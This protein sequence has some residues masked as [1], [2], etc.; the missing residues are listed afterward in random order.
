MSTLPDA[1]AL[2]SGSEIP[3][4]L[5]IRI[6][7][8][9]PLADL[10][11][12]Q[13][14]SRDWKTLIQT[15]PALQYKIE[16]GLAGLADNPWNALDTATKRR[17]LATY[18]RAW[19]SNSKPI[20]PP[21]TL[22]VKRLGR[23]NIGGRPNFVLRPDFAGVF[24]VRDPDP[25]HGN[26]ESLSYEQFSSQYLDIE[27]KSIRVGPHPGDG[28]AFDMTQDLV[29]SAFQKTTDDFAIHLCCSML[30]T[31]MAHPL[32]GF[33]NTPPTPSTE[34]EGHFIINGPYVALL[35]Q[36]RTN[37]QTAKRSM[38]I[39]WQWKAG[40]RILVDLVP[41]TGGIS[42]LD[43]KYIVLA[44]TIS[45]VTSLLSIPALTVFDLELVENNA[46]S[47][48]PERSWT[49]LLPQCNEHECNEIVLNVRSGPSPG[50]TPRTSS[51]PLDN[52]TNSELQQPIFFATPEDRVMLFT[53]CI[54]EADSAHKAYVRFVTLASKLLKLVRDDELPAPRIYPW[55][56]WGPQAVRA[57]PVGYHD[58]RPL[59]SAPWG[60]RFAD[61]VVCHHDSPNHEA[62]A[63][64]SDLVTSPT[65]VWRSALSHGMG[66]LV[67]DYNQASIRKSLWDARGV[68]PEELRDA[69]RT[70]ALLGVA[71]AKPLL[72]SDGYQYH[73]L[74][75]RL[76]PDYARYFNDPDDVRT[77]LPY[78]KR[79]TNI[80][81]KCPHTTRRGPVQEPAPSGN[82]ALPLHRPLINCMLIEDTIIIERRVG[83]DSLQTM[84]IA[85]D[86]QGVAE[87]HDD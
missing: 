84:A 11:R 68:T 21:Q 7:E 51:A 29:V 81:I 22:N 85:L 62:H 4:E 66:V 26:E 16:L 3:T 48:Q 41:Y 71:P 60:M 50:W 63:V 39:V 49:F 76:P 30:S 83:H 82:L 32:S 42:F 19:Y 73:V 67:Y 52:N 86:S 24:R 72:L 12:L 37:T 20:F 59:K 9:L 6:L 44:R 40:R 13:L 10:V 56:I 8:N 77:W 31:G 17:K 65:Q 75:S 78:R 38:V 27:R 34:I 2:S 36:A 80:W 33:G 55:N 54:S 15:V 45:S 28:R 43:S 69:S 1:S 47:Y 14:V 70:S 5:L 23:T 25:E 74:P 79:E 58:V 61:S 87:E 57:E 46:H 18:R 53:L 64:E 35:V